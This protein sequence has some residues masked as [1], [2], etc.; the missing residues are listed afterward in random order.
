MHDYA[1]MITED[2]VVIVSGKLDEKED[3]SRLF[4]DGVEIVEEIIPEYPLQIVLAS[5]HHTTHHLDAIKRI[6]TNHPGNTPVQILLNT[7]RMCALAPDFNIDVTDESKSALEELLG[8]G[9]ATLKIR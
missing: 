3:S 7:R 2:A 5:Q 1:E 8:V 4:L 9:T 6:I